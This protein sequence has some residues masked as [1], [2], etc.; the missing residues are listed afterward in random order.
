MPLSV[1]DRATLTIITFSK[2]SLKIQETFRRRLWLSL[3][4]ALD[5]S[6]EIAELQ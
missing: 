3:S 4:G 2:F 6:Q 5:F 1:Y